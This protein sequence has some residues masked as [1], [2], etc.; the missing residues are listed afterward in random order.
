[1]TAATQASSVP[2]GVD[3]AVHYLRAMIP[4]GPGALSHYEL[5][6]GWSRAN[7]YPLSEMSSKSGFKVYD[8][9]RCQ[10]SG[11][12]SIAKTPVEGVSLDFLDRIERYAL[13]DGVRAAPACLQEQRGA[14]TFQ[15]LLP[16]H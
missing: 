15:H 13:N 6:Q 11:W 3:H 4:L 7:A 12:P 8:S 16:S 5:R 10:D 2:S 9:R 1:V 14:T